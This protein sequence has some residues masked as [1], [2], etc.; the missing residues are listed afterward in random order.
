MKRR[1]LF[2]ATVTA[3]IFL[4]CT[5]SKNSPQD[6]SMNKQQP[7]PPAVSLTL[8]DAEK[9][10]GE[11]AHITDSTNT[12]EDNV[13]TYRLSYTANTV[14]LKTGKTG[15]IYYLLEQFDNV[16]SAQKKYSSIKK[17]NED[18][19]GVKILHNLG[20]EAYFHSDGEN[21][22]FVMVRYKE[23]MFNMKVNKIT[24]KT[25]LNEFNTAAENITAGLSK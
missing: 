21:F 12:V 18:H 8:P 11:P 15:A 22:Y 23:K 6:K 17:S 2:L 16:S 24:S 9:I 13:S 7:K 10:L 3:L 20:D 19:E 25:S 14:D 4:C 5:Q 1:I